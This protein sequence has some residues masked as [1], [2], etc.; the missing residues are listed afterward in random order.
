MMYNEAGWHAVGKEGISEGEAIDLSLYVYHDNPYIAYLDKANDWKAT[1]LKFN[2]MNWETVG[3]EGFSAEKAHFQSL[4]VY[5]GT[6][7][8]AYK[9]YANGRKAT[10]LKFNG[11]SWEAVGSPGISEI[12]ASYTS[13]FMDNGTLYV[14]FKD[15]ANSW[16]VSVM[17]FTGNT[18]TDSDGQPNDGWEYVGSPGFSAGTVLYTSLYV[19]NDIPYICYED[20]GAS[21]R[22][23]V[24][25][26]DGSWQYVGSQGFTPGRAEYP[27]LHMYNGTPYVAYREINA[28]TQLH[29]ASVMKYNGTS[30]EDVGTPGFSSGTADY[31]SLFVYSGTPYVAYRDWANLN[32]VT[33]M[34]LW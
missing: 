21:G 24:M 10:V 30:W 11:T 13:L 20:G 4:C 29:K 15:R 26:Y 31:N 8:V 18:E 9:D 5:E 23:T 12:E 6:P 22:A 2:G 16:Y 25:K 1:V 34:R 19:Y 17:E 32:K 33:V 14:A 3:I 7:Y 28:S 27:S